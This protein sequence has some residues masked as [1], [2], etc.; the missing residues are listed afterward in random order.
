[1]VVGMGGRVGAHH[2][3]SRQRLLNGSGCAGGLIATQGTIFQG[4]KLTDYYFILFFFTIFPYS[5]ECP[6]QL[7]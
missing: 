2:R 5:L 3:P 4:H 6:H 1:M 7:Y